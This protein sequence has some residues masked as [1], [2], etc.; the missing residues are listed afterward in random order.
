M[1]DTLILRRP[2]GKLV[3]MPAR[4]WAYDKART[5]LTVD[6]SKGVTFSRTHSGPLPTLA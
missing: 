5:A 6:L 2:D 1:Y 4:K 3:P